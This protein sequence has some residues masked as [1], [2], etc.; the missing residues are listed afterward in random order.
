MSKKTDPKADTETA[1]AVAEVAQAQPQ[2]QPEASLPPTLAAMT[3]AQLKAGAKKA[4]KAGD[5]TTAATLRAAAVL[6]EQQAKQKQTEKSA[7]SAAVDAV[8]S[9]MQKVLEICYAGSADTRRALSKALG[10]NETDIPESPPDAPFTTRQSAEPPFIEKTSRSR[11]TGTGDDRP[12]VSAADLKGANVDAFLMPDGSDV[13]ALAAVNN[14]PAA[15]HPVTYLI[16]FAPDS[17]CFYDRACRAG[18]EIGGANE[19]KKYT[20]A[21]KQD[22]HDGRGLRHGDAVSRTFASL[23]VADEEHK[24]RMQD[25]SIQTVKETLAQILSPAPAA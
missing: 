13:T 25:G 14:K 1:A 8:I 10:I 18:H 7:K 6:V 9:L 4:E 22:M 11:K 3:P 19:L 15:V 12:A 23:A 24:V 20:D 21:Q 16:N 5:K 2:A 17:V